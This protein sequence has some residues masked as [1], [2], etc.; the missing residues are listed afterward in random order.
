M[1]LVGEIATNDIRG[2]L[3]SCLQL[4][5]TIGI[6]FAYV[7]GNFLALKAFNF[8]CATLPLVFGLIFIWMPESPYYYVMKNRIQDAESSLKWLRGE[9]FDYINELAN[10]KTE[11]EIS[12]RNSASWSIILSKPATRRGIMISLILLLFTQLSGINA[13]IFYTGSIFEQTK[14]NITSTNATII[15]GVMQVVA[16]FTASLTVDHL[17]RRLL[18]IMSATTMC[19]C[20]IG[21]G[22]YF[23]LLDHNYDSIGSLSWLP[24]S[25]LCIYIIAFA[26]GLGPIPW[27]LVCCF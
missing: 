26:L 22:V 7:V 15:V 5:I 13:V 11:H 17:G 20:N 23:Y 12:V 21:L 24:I 27:V 25:S 9:Q 10:I 4:M 8:V 3:G 2:T 19:I 18:L 1:F 14:S 6:L 16:T